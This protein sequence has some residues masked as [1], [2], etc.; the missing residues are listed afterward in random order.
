MSVGALCA[1]ALTFR[2]LSAAVEKFKPF[3][4][5]APTKSKLPCPTETDYNDK[6]IRFFPSLNKYAVRSK[7]APHIFK[8]SEII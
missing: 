8:L 3:L 2:F 6:R 4:S 7:G 1:C 5:R